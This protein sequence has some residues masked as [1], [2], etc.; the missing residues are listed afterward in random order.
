MRFAEPFKLTGNLS[1]EE[2]LEAERLMFMELTQGLC[3]LLSRGQDH[4]QFSSLPLGQFN[5]P[6]VTYQ[7]D[8]RTNQSAS[9]YWWRS[10]CSD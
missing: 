8:G 4:K 6:F 10:S 2:K 1:P 9:V 7:H 5:R 3:F